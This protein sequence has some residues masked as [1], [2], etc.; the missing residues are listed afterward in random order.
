MIEFYERRCPHMVGN[1]NVLTIQIAQWGQEE[2][3]MQSKTTA[4]GLRWTK[5][6]Y[7]PQSGKVKELIFSC[8]R[9][10]QQQQQSTPFIY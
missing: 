7:C 9:W 10:Q 2:Q 5:S 6:I 8:S 3:I 4:G 1:V